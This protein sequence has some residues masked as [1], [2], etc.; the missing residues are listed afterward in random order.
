M[1]FFLGMVL[2][3]TAVV[4]VATA[5]VSEVTGAMAVASE[6]IIDTNNNLP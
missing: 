5:E 6:G 1:S 4:S 3:A 2:M